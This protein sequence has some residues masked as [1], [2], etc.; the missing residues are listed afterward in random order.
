MSN[1][2][3][4]RKRIAENFRRLLLRH[5]QDWNPSFE[6]A[7]W[8]K[9]SQVICE[10][11]DSDGLIDHQRVLQVK[12]HAQRMREHPLRLIRLKRRALNMTLAQAAHK[13][14]MPRSYWNMIELGQRKLT[15]SSAQKIAHSLDLPL[16]KLLVG[17]AP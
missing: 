17:S 8:R 5:H 2:K 16:E 14:N 12:T 9:G 7:F 15:L 13:A 3:S 1:W 11:Q 4:P 6:I 10:V